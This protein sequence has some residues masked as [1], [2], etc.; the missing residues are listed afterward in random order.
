MWTRVWL[1][2]ATCFHLLWL[3][4]KTTI[5]RGIEGE[6]MPFLFPPLHL[7]FPPFPSPRNNVEDQ[8]NVLYN[9]AT[10]FLALGNH[11]S[12]VLSSNLDD[13]FVMHLYRCQSDL[14][15]CFGAKVASPK[16]EIQM[17]NTFDWSSIL[18]RG[19]GNDG[20]ENKMVEMEM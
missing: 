6:D 10:R 1:W 12:Q 9:K 20:N 15:F 2:A 11:K 5:R 19:D 13:V 8:S 14:I 18:L 17:Y 4:L 16:F 7:H 3:K